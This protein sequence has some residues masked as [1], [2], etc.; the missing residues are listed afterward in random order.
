MWGCPYTATWS[1]KME[2]GELIGPK[3]DSGPPGKPGPKGEKGDPG[4]GGI[5]AIKANGVII[6]AGAVNITAASVG[7]VSELTGSWF[8]PAGDL[9]LPLTP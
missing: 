6:P 1:E 9:P 2:N 4:E 5:T 7:G 3:G 8:P